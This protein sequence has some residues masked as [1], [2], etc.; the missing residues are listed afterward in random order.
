MSSGINLKIWMALKG[1]I[2]TLPLSYPKAWP[3]ETFEVPGISPFI[4]VGRVVAAPAGQMIKYGKP[5]LRT[6]FIILT[7]V[8]PISRGEIPLGQAAAYFDN[9]SGQIAEHFTDGTIMTFDG[10]CVTVT[11]YPHVQEG[12]L[13][14]GFWNIPVR[15]PWRIYA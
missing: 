7:L 2:D 10:V 14:G 3:A 13:D 15:I 8:Y 1:R 4:R 11:D 5:H 9:I 6:G 12:Y